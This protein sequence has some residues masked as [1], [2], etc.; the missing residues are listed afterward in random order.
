MKYNLLQIFFGI[1]FGFLV[2]AGIGQY[3]KGQ[4]LEQSIVSQT[5]TAPTSISQTKIFQV[6][7]SIFGH[8]YKKRDF[9]DLVKHTEDKRGTYGIYIRDLNTNTAYTYN[10]DLVFFAASLYKVPVAVGVFKSIENQSL[11]LETSI[12]YSKGDFATGSGTI[13]NSGIRKSYTVDDLVNRL[14][15]HSDNIAQNMLMRT[16]DKVVMRESFLVYSGNTDKNFY[17]NQLASPLLIGTIFENL[18]FEAKGKRV[19]QPYLS[20]ENAEQV[21]TRMQET[22]F[23]N[24]IHIGLPT[25]AVFYHKIGNWG[26]EGSWHD[27]GIAETSS[28]YSVCVMSVNTSYEDFEKVSEEVGNFIR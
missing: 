19:F 8:I 27:C 13:A 10:K 25:G 12:N 4:N 18:Y 24:R 26:E 11:T 22:S 6:K 9:E 2:V 15:K 17:E 21:L 14:L 23:D 3:N 1:L 7:N 16:V 20:K 28:V 5:T